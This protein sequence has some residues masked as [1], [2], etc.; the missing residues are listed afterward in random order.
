MLPQEAMLLSLGHDAAP[1]P[2]EAQSSC[3]CLWSGLPLKVMLKSE[4]RVTT[5]DK[6]NVCGLCYHRRTC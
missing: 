3:G 5:G 4:A 6:V 2:V 1:S